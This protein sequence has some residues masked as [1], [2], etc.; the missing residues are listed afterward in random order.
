MGQMI[1]LKSAD[2]HVFEAYEAIPEKDTRGGLVLLQEVFGLN[3]YI[4]RRCD[5]YARLGYHV[6]APALFDRIS[7]NLQLGYALED[8]LKGRDLR[9]SIGWDEVL[10]DT[11]AAVAR[12]DADKPKGAIG[13]CWG[14]TIAWLA[15]TRIPGISAASCYYGTQILAFADERPACPVLMHFAE[16][17]HVVSLDQVAVIAEKV[18]GTS[19][20]L[21]IYEGDHGFACDERAAFHAE[22]AALA[23]DRTARLFGLNLG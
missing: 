13:Y 18:A 7:R 23:N 3:S 2:G 5:H 10:L 15:A 9:E 21:F 8:G 19:V 16:R 6:V 20:E 14:G 22:S 11:R 4:R 1:E 17:D 12:L